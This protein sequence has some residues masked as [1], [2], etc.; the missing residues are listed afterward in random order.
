[1]TRA[2]G[3]WGRG[4]D[5]KSYLGPAIYGHVILIDCLGYIYSWLVSKSFSGYKICIRTKPQMKITKCILVIIA[6]IL[7][8]KYLYDFISKPYL[9][10][11]AFLWLS[12]L[13]YSGTIR[14]LQIKPK[15][16]KEKKPWFI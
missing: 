15:R 14:K 12:N 3:P 2:W 6:I 16:T 10:A 9:K 11:L 1:M 7:M 8:I 13:S 5:G 4:T